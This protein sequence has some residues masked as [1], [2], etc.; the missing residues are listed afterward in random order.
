MTLTVDGNASQQAHIQTFFTDTASNYPAS[1]TDQNANGFATPNWYY[2]YNQ[3]YAST[4]SYDPVSTYSY[5]DAH[6]PPSYP[7]HIA[8]DAYG[9]SSIRV[10]DINPVSP[11]YIRYVGDL[12]INGVH[13]FIYVCAHEAGHQVLFKQGGVYNF[14]ADPA[15][16]SPVSADGDNVSDIWEPVH[17]LNPNISDTT[18]AYGAQSNGDV[19]DNEVLADIPAL[20]VIFQQVATWKQDWANGGLQVG[21]NSYTLGKPAGFYWTFHALVNGTTWKAGISYS[22][23]SIKDLQNQYPSLLISLP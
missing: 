1:A 7:I 11:N 14:S 4:G 22:V 19:G 5:T 23:Y 15:D 21:S 8:N 13:R 12:D 10:F 6:S 9:A 17:H 20:P 18:G 2:Y 3:V 16:T